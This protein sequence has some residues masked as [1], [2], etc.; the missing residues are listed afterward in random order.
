MQ[1]SLR[2]RA[3]AALLAGLLALDLVLNLWWH[4]LGK[5]LKDLHVGCKAVPADLPSLGRRVAGSERAVLLTVL[6]HEQA[7][8]ATNFLAHLKA[9]GLLPRLL[10]VVLD[11]PSAALAVEYSVAPYRVR[12]RGVD[13]PRP[14]AVCAASAED[15]LDSSAQVQAARWRYFAALVD[16]GLQVWVADVRVVWLRDPL[17]AWLPPAQC[18]LALVSEAPFGHELPA[19]RGNASDGDAHARRLSL[20]LSLGLHRPVPSVAAWHLRVGRRLSEHGAGAGGRPMDLE[21]Q[22]VA[23]ELA[24]CPGAEAAGPEARH[25]APSEGCPRWCVLPAP[26]FPNGLQYFQH[27]VPQSTTP[28]SRPVAILASWLPRAQLRYR[29]L[30]EGLWRAEPPHEET[31]EAQEAQE[32]QEVQEAQAGGPERFIVFK[33][34]VIN[35]GLSNTRNALRSAL[36]IAQITNRT[37]ILPPLWS[38][39]LHGEPYR[40]GVDYYFDWSRL[41]RA[42]P[43][44]REAAYLRRAFPSA[45]AW[46]PDA[47]PLFFVQLHAGEQLCHE[48]T[49]AVCH[50]RL[51]PPAERTPQARPLLTRAR[52]APRSPSSSRGSA[53]S[54][55]PARRCSC[56]PAS[57]AR[58]RRSTSTSAPRRPSCAHGWRRTRTS[59]CSTSG[60]CSAAS[61]ASP[62]RSSTPTSRAASPGACSPHPRYAPSPRKR[63][64]ACAA[65]SAAAASTAYTCDGARRRGSGRP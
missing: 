48:R 2:R 35:N 14:A 46:P 55:R 6:R 3:L 17:S 65:P 54:T 61:T 21:R 5:P 42:F 58:S 15:W 62:R 25:A 47:Y 28:P 24:R 44:V 45:A 23:E 1:C 31:Q 53:T 49:D 30:E 38:R 39:H 40:V 22:I 43:R 57:C 52:L 12:I 33:E 8:E 56:G 59:R 4:N 9:A 34:L 13:A 7:E 63:C 10:A 18:D 36:A 29:L 60:A 16:A 32:A 50:A 19:P 26:L 11:E 20:S 37:L 41:Q 27:R 51:K 64:S